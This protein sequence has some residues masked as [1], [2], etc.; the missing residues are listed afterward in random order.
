[1]YSNIDNNEDVFASAMEE[2]EIVENPFVQ[3]GDAGEPLHASDAARRLLGDEQEE[4]ENV[5]DV[6]PLVDRGAS[7]RP[8][9]GNSLLERIQQQKAQQHLSSSS[10]AQPMTT[11]ATAT[12]AS[13][14]AS[15]SS[16]FGYPVVQEGMYST[17]GTTGGSSG[18]VRVPQYSQ[19]PPPSA[20]NTN[21]PY[22]ST[23][24]APSNTDYKEQ[25]MNVLSIVGTAAGTAAKGAYNGTKYVYGKMMKTNTNNT[26]LHVSSAN[27]GMG[28]VP[29]GAG[30][31][32]MDY[33]RESLLMDPHDLED[34]AAASTMGS[35]PTAMNAGGG[36]MTSGM[37]AGIISA[38]NNAGNENSI[39]TCMK[40][41]A[42]DMKDLF[43]GASRGVQIGV[44]ALIVFIIWLLFFE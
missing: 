43:L 39:V 9:M 18:D 35:I 40:Q 32:E 4:E 15:D 42:V 36:G 24:P 31:T 10:S 16:E 23:T 33:Q 21:S 7:S 12:A 13:I 28:G 30:M 26:G 11:T 2:A 34:R 44:I 37:R 6:T 38:N 27:G 29:G 8:T 14:L 3:G 41:F 5:E 17:P 20:Y 19:I 25:M 1:M 22:T